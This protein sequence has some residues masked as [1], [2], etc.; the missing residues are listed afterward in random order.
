MASFRS[1]YSKLT[2]KSLITSR[3]EIKKG[4]GNFLWTKITAEGTGIQKVEIVYSYGPDPIERVSLTIDDPPIEDNMVCAG[5]SVYNKLQLVFLAIPEQ[6]MKSLV[7]HAKLGDSDFDKYLSLFLQGISIHIGTYFMMTYESCSIGKPFGV[8]D[9]KMPE[10][11]IKNDPHTKNLYDYSSYMIDMAL[12]IYGPPSTKNDQHCSKRYVGVD[13]MAQM[14]FYWSNWGD[15]FNDGTYYEPSKSIYASNLAF[16]KHVRHT[17]SKIEKSKTMIDVLVEDSKNELCTIAEDLANSLKC[18]CDTIQERLQELSDTADGIS[19]KME[20]ETHEQLQNLRDAGD[21]E[22][23]RLTETSCCQTSKFNTLSDEAKS[24]LEDTALEHLNMISSTV[25]TLENISERSHIKRM[26]ELEKKDAENTEKIQSAIVSLQE[27]GKK[28]AQRVHDQ[29]MDLINDIEHRKNHTVNLFITR[30]TESIKKIEDLA[31][32]VQEKQSSDL[33]SMKSDMRKELI[34][35]MKQ[36]ES[37]NCNDIE[38]CCKDVSDTLEKIEECVR[39]TRKEIDLMKQE[40]SRMSNSEATLKT[41]ESK[42]QAASERIDKCIA[43][44]KQDVRKMKDFMKERESSGCAKSSHTT[45]A[46]MNMISALE[47]RISALEGN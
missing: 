10:I 24:S 18:Q 15:C 27:S 12:A 4:S 42:I 47:E 1:Q 38:Q 3:E 31:E 23:Q 40:L 32:M 5:D 39:T 17:T 46:V 33:D 45:D 7:K 8:L 11:D 9:P 6:E 2:S 26:K 14:K 36:I 41:N 19:K 44:I 13:A 21:E 30:S 22:I 16:A 34:T 25:Q 28:S 29:A 35:R 43:E 37:D 20:K